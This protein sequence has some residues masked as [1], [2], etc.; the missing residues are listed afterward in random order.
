LDKE[1]ADNGRIKGFVRI[2]T[3]NDE[4]QK[5]VKQ[6]IQE[7]EVCEYLRCFTY[8]TNTILARADQI[9]QLS[10]VMDESDDATDAVEFDRAT[11][12]FLQ[13]NVDPVAMSDFIEPLRKKVQFANRK[14][15][16]SFKLKLVVEPP[17]EGGGV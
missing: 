2:P 10:L 5:S 6:I 1:Y 14:M 12:R 3:E 17:E 11:K 8:D 7:N 16:R 13:G 4:K 9:I 15:L